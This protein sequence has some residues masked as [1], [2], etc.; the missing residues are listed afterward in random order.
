M[1]LTDVTTKS[2]HVRYP[3]VIVSASAAH[4]IISACI[5]RRAPCVILYYPASTGPS[6]QGAYVGG[7][8]A[9]VISPAESKYKTRGLEHK[10]SKGNLE[11]AY[12]PQQTSCGGGPEE[13]SWTREQC[14][15]R[16]RLSEKDEA[17]GQGTLVGSGSSK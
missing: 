16:R 4:D 15:S 3:G 5:S 1:N 11:M 6:Q 8:N 2:S 12:D 10:M 7:D 14:H 9:N 13:R 17:G